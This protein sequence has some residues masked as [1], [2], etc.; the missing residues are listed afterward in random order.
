MEPTQ[1]NAPGIDALGTYRISGLVRSSL[2]DGGISILFGLEI[3]VFVFAFPF[4]LIFFSVGWK[5]EEEK[6]IAVFT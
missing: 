3:D 5:E 6:A 4:A 1:H 2:H